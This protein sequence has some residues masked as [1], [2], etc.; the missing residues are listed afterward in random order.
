MPVIPIEPNLIS[1]DVPGVDLRPR[2]SGVVG[3][4]LAGVGQDLARTGFGLMEQ[5]QHAEAKD[6]AFREKADDMLAGEDFV[7]EL[8]M[9]NPTGYV[10][11]SKTG[12]FMTNADGTRR[13]ITQEYREWAN[14]RFESKQR[15]MPSEIARQLYHQEAGNYYVSSQLSL[16]RE[17]DVLKARYFDDGQV[18]NLQ[19]F[20]DNLVSRPDVNKVYEF[21]NTIMGAEMA[22]VGSTRSSVVASENA[23][24]YN[25]Q[26]AE[27]VLEGGYNQV[28]SGIKSGNKAFN[29]SDSVAYWRGVLKGED[30]TSTLRK[31]AGLPTVAEMLDPDRKAA[32]DEKFIRLAD[33]AKD[34]DLS[35]LRR[36]KAEIKVALES[37]RGGRAD[38]QAY[39]SGVE[40]AVREKKITEFEAGS[41]YISD[42]AE[43][44][45]IG[46]LSKD[47]FALM[48]PSDRMVEV[49]K[50]G[51]RVY[52]EAQ[53]AAPNAKV[54]GSINQAE[55][56]GRM[57]GYAQKLLSAEQND[58]AAYLA[59]HDPVSRTAAAQL[60]SQ[61]PRR[62]GKTP[63][64]FSS[65]FSRTT[66][67][68]S[69]T[70]AGMTAT[71]GSSARVPPS[72]CLRPSWIIAV[73]SS[74]APKP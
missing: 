22:Q 71:S 61:S 14:E 52:A 8:K 37:G 53:K 68:T 30:E 67:T 31:Q 33:L 40:K 73:P 9:K 20:S 7:T 35:D 74:S 57:G 66:P 12:E 41:D 62:S 3:S 24:K 4:A 29:R 63:S 27:S 65:F 2:E 64:T 70:S 45:E 16:R 1:T 28:L 15:K 55:I 6:A 5:M 36:Q 17:E 39:R 51:A 60:T 21:S 25:H 38:L 18:S 59:E 47:K 49:K 23:R 34:L 13:T 48:K 69:A 43:S 72:R 10:T 11:D 50:S 42:V 56:E 19:K 26:L 32:L 58:F 46:R 54:A 44:A